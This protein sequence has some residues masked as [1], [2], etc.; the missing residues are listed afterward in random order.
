[1]AE[2]TIPSFFC[3]KRVTNLITELL[4]GKRQAKHIGVP[5]G[6]KWNN[7]WAKS[8]KAKYLHIC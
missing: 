2:M 4:F 3:K 5:F 8:V 7:P 6:N 1:M